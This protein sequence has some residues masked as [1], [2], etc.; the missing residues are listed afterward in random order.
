VGTTLLLLRVV[1]ARESAGQPL[2]EAT[3][4][5]EPPAAATKPRAYSDELMDGLSQEVQQ[6]PEALAQLL[7]AWMREE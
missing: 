3:E 7:R 1:R 6:R 4:G 2:P 5:P